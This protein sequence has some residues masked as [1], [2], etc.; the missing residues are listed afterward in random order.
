MISAI[1]TVDRNWGIGKNGKQITNIPDDAR[2]IRAVTTDGCVIMGRVTYDSIPEGQL[3]VNRTNIVLSKRPGFR[4]QGA[5]PA[6][7]LE[8]ALKIAGEKGTDIYVLGGGQVFAQ[9]LDMLDE[10]QVTYIDYL[11]D[12]DTKFPNLDKRPE[13]VMVSESEEQ[14]HFDTIYYRRRYIRRKDYQ[15]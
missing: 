5:V 12:T 4:P 9:M 2:Y 6:T 15:A 10:V 11:Y 7:S 14:T 13:W 1:V 8:E 3:P